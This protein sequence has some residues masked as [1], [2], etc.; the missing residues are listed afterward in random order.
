MKDYEFE[1][2]VE[3]VARLSSLLM[4]FSEPVKPK[5]EPEEDGDEREEA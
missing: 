1:M 3:E 5:N 2:S 4:T